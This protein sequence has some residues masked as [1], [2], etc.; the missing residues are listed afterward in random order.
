MKSRILRRWLLLM[1]FILS[2]LPSTL[3]AHGGGTPRLTNA[4]AGPYR[5][6]AWSEPEPWRV[7][8]VHLSL[9]VTQPNPDAN[10]SQVEIPVDEAEIL[11]TFAPV[12]GTSEPIVVPAVRQAFL[13][14]FYFEADTMLPSEGNWQMT[15]DV[16][17]DKGSGSTEFNIEAL[18][19]RTINWTLVASAGGVLV[20]LLVLIAIW[21]RAQQSSQSVRPTRPARPG[22]S[23]A[24]TKNQPASSSKSDLDSGSTV[25]AVETTPK[26]ARK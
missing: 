25:G 18:E 16:T 22:R 15:I 2:G 8:E 17:G 9:A 6:Y 1:A 20:V 7:G 3:Y 14:D 24:R 11:V 5:V 12:D 26:R 13:G 21:S 23:G 4:P 10:S 19:A